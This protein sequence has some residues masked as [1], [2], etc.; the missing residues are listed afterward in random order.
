MFWG[1]IQIHLSREETAIKNLERQGFEVFCPM[2]R[3]SRGIR[4]TEHKRLPLFPGY[5]F[6]KLGFDQAWRCIN[7]TTGVIRLLSSRAD[8]DPHPLK[9]PEDIIM[10]LQGTEK[11]E[12][13]PPNTQVRVRR[14]DSKMYDMVGTVVDMSKSDRVCVLMQLFNRDTV[15]EFT[16]STD[17]EVVA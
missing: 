4:P 13:L 5:L 3:C 9:V 12:E 1:C 10:R 8:R 11:V 14:R 2:Y 16:D 7:S 6:V 17:L 15:V